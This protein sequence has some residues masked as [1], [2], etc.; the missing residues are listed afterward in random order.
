MTAGFASAEV[1]LS[2]STDSGLSFGAKIDLDEA[3]LT[4]DANETVWISGAFGTITMGDTDSAI[5]FVNAEAA[6]GVILA[7]DFTVLDA[8]FQNYLDEAT[9]DTVA[10]WNYSVNNLT[11][12]ASAEIGTNAAS[13]N[14]SYSVGASYKMAISGGSLTL[15]GGYQSHEG[16]LS[17]RASSAFSSAEGAEVDNTTAIEDS[18]V[19]GVSAALKLDSGLGLTATYAAVDN[20]SATDATVLTAAGTTTVGALNDAKV[21]SIGADYTVGDLTVGASYAKL[22]SDNNDEDLKSYG[23]GASYA[24]GTGARAFG[25]MKSE[26]VGNKAATEQYQIGMAFS[27]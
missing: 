14:N 19:V 3:A 24:L 17:Y 26:K 12:A 7:D 15:G 13:G 16:R 6:Q 5:D 1:T 8:G 2:G 25:A 9:D 10:R 11:L 4:N 18:S 22:N 20:Y 23:L 21:M 27:F